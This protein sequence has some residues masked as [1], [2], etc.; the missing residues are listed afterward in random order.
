MNSILILLLISTS[1]AA[2][3]MLPLVEPSE[4]VEPDHIGEISDVKVTDENTNKKISGANFLEKHQKFLS[5]LDFFDEASQVPEEPPVE[6]LEEAI[7][8]DASD[9]ESGNRQK[10]SAVRGSMVN[11]IFLV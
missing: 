3:P 11:L 2:P 9:E 10:Q 6:V 4:S 7:E 5:W 1:L 8:I